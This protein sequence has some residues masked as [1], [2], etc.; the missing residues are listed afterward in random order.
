M[1]S[2]PPSTA[3]VDA[4]SPLR[5]QPPPC[6][7]QEDV[8]ASLTPEI[9]VE[10]TEGDD[11][12]WDAI[13][14]PAPA[15][16]EPIEPA[17]RTRRGWE[18]AAPGAVISPSAQTAIRV[19]PART[20]RKR[21]HKTIPPAAGIAPASAQAC[22]GKTRGER[23][24]A[25]SLTET[26]ELPS[27]SD[28]AEVPLFIARAVV[29]TPAEPQQPPT[30]A[31]VEQ[32]PITAQSGQIALEPKQPSTPLEDE[33]AP[34]PAEPEPEA[35]LAGEEEPSGPARQEEEPSASEA[36]EPPNPPEEE[37]PRSVWEST[38]SAFRIGRTFDKL[39]ERSASRRSAD[40]EEERTRTPLWDALTA[41][42]RE[43][44]AASDRLQIR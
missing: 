32:A 8:G 6:F 25:P 14:N 7:D 16:P 43:E 5:S 23:Q 24:R 31:E 2:A 28:T 18:L 12:D 21:G 4:P 10:T 37:R 27:F 20:G 34:I 42:A 13:F 35:V 30:P 11:I 39:W 36:G 33:Q 29:P 26:A 19:P 44:A 15:T 40:A 9:S 22:H 3:W 17:P 38:A 41:R 1:A